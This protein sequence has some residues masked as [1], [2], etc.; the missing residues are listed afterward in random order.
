MHPSG[1]ALLRISGSMPFGWYAVYTRHQHEKS[2]AQS[3]TRKGFEV[4]LPL[5]RSA[6]RWKDR[7][8]VVLLPLFPNYLFVQVDLERRVDV[9]CA[10][11]ICWF[12]GNGC[13]PTGI[14]PEDIKA[15]RRLVECPISLQPHPYLKCGD[16][17]R[18]IRG[19]FA[20]LQGVLVRAKNGHR[21]VISVDLLQKSAA[22]EVDLSNLE[23]I[24]PLPQ[25][26]KS[27]EEIHK[28]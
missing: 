7:T 5:Y 16:V 27:P 1:S 28:C 13:A 11:G 12:V 19:P 26:G 2:S 20:G 17:V 3:L 6:N 24:S 15:I 18:V 21:V 25:L 4:L 14:P 9:L 22:F 10:P 8:Q 23:R